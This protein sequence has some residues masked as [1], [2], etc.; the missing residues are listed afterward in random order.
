MTEPDFAIPAP[1]NFPQMELIFA[2]GKLEPFLRRV[3]ERRAA[4]RPIT[5]SPGADGR[6]AKAV[7]AAFDTAL[8]LVERIDRIRQS[9][10][11]SADSGRQLERG[12][13]K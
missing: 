3:E 11:T 13:A 8:A 6:R 7:L 10:A 12:A 4:L 5:A 2:D 1:E 9:A